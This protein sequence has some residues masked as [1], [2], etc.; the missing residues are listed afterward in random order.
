MQSRPEGNKLPSPTIKTAS[1]Q[2]LSVQ[3][4]E[5]LKKEGRCFYCREVGH[6]FWECPKKMV[7]QQRNDKVMP[8]ELKQA[9]TPNLTKK[10]QQG[11][12]QP[13]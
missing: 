12:G 10:S 13:Q 9:S 5:R 7:R 2:K 4:R 6:G 3:E 1:N 11:N 8:I